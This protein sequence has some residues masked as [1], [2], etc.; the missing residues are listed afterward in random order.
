MKTKKYIYVGALAAAF[1]LGSCSDDFLKV[2]NP[3]GEPLEE[4]YTTDAHLQ[5]SVTAAYDPLHWPDWDGTAYNALNIDA[6][7]MGD[8]F[9]PGGSNI[10]DNQHWHKLFNFEG[11]GNN[12]LST[13]WGDFYSGIKRC[14]DVLTYCAYDANKDNTNLPTYIEQARLLRVYY[15][16]ILWHYYGDIPFYLTNL[17]SPYQADQISADKVYENLIAEMEDILKNNVLPMRWDNANAGRVSKAFAYMLYAELV[18][19]QNDTARYPQALAYMKEI[20]NSGDYSLMSNFADIWKESGEWGSESI[21]EI[22]YQDDQ[23]GRDWGTSKSAGGT[24]LPTLISPNGWQGGDGWSAGQDGWGFLPMRVE[25]Y[26]MYEDGDQRRD[27]TCW[28]VRS[29]L[30]TD[31]DYKARYQDTHIWL[32]KYRPMDDNNK[33]CP[34][35]KN[36]NYNNNLRVYRYAETLLNAAELTLATG[37]SNGEATGYLNQ[38]HRRAGLPAMTSITEDDILNERHLEFVGEGKRYFDLVRTGK[39]ATTLVAIPGSDRTNSWT[40]NKK[41]VPL[42]QS[43][44]DNDPKLHQNDYTK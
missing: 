6:E 36:L 30:G 3:S 1:L 39:A 43:E 40:P 41:H 11:D 25:T 14:N 34:T 9:F 37:G 33:D 31:K 2:E 20:I 35:S 27:A 28:D 7:I 24:V 29:L 19:Y 10:S 15:Y 32:A 17:S 42:A 44:L 22:N 38:V 16:D 12:T 21:F 18:M 4:Y 13:L 23:A 5:E 8:D 26:N